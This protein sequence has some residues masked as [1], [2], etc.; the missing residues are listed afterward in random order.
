MTGFCRTGEMFAADLYEVE[1]DLLTMGK[2]INSSYL[3][4]GAF[5]ISDRIIEVIHGLSLSGF[6]HAAHPL[7]LAGADA[8]IDV[9][10]EDDVAAG[11]RAMSRYVKA[12]FRDE[13]VELDVAGDVDDEDLMLALEI[14]ENTSSKERLGAEIMGR[15]TTRSVDRGLITRGGGSRLAF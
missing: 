2:G 8:A 14:V 6:T 9:Y 11:V 10:L 3:P 13:F 15:I 5:D 1:P 7:A 12:R 4:C